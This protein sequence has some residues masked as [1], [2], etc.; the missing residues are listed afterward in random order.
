[1]LASFLSQCKQRI[2]AGQLYIWNEGQTI[3][4]V[5]RWAWM[6][7]VSIHVSQMGARGACES[8]ET[9]TGKRPV[10]GNLNDKT[11]IKYESKDTFVY[12]PGSAIRPHKYRRGITRCVDSMHG[13]ADK[14]AERSGSCFW[15]AYFSCY[16]PQLAF[17]RIFGQGHIYNCQEFV[18]SLVLMSVGESVLAFY[19]YHSLLNRWF[20]Q[21]LERARVSMVISMR[22]RW[23]YYFS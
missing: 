11:R 17:E 9:R 20:G 23:E 12:R 7:I 22:I 16:L 6:V 2:Y 18:V 5:L 21:N 14:I 4:A 19:D 1:M 10:I 3:S 13:F 15:D 8:R